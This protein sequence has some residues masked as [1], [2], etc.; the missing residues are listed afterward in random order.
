L[1]AQSKGE[2]KTRQR[3]TGGGRKEN[4]KISRDREVQKD[5]TKPKS[6][7]LSESGKEAKLRLRPDA[8]KKSTAES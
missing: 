3:F 8:D 4:K 2:N 7:I 5:S 1:A 6:V